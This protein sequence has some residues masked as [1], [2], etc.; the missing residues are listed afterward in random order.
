MIEYIHCSRRSRRHYRTL[1]ST[2]NCYPDVP[3]CT[4]H[5]YVASCMARDRACLS[6]VTVEISMLSPQMNTCI[7][8]WGS[9]FQDRLIDVH[10]MIDKFRIVHFVCIQQEH[11][12]LRKV[13]RGNLQSSEYPITFGIEPGSFVL[14]SF[15]RINKPSFQC[16]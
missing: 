5:H 7:T 6:P 14:V 3:R 9:W 11:H 4:V 15:N 1:S 16:Y 2:H 8:G 13:S 12:R 10:N